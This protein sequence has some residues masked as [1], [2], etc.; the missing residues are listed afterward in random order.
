MTVC[1]INVNVDMAS[2]EIK[3]IFAQ[4]TVEDKREIATKVAIEYFKAQMKTTNHG[5]SNYGHQETFQ[6]K[7]LKD[8]SNQLREHIGTQL[9]SDPELKKQIDFVIDQL[10]KNWQAFVQA[11]IGNALGKMIGQ[12]LQSINNLEQ[13]AQILRGRLSLLDNQ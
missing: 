9:S 5:Y 4:L 12:T 8:I 7:F 13:D 6:E 1:S 2:P 3:D 10:S 11:S